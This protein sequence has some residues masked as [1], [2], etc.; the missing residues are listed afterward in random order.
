MGR[1]PTSSRQSRERVADSGPPVTSERADTVR[2]LLVT[3]REP[4]ASAQG[5]LDV[6]GTPEGSVGIGGQMWGV[7]SVPDMTFGEGTCAKLSFE[8]MHSSIVGGCNGSP[9]L[10]GT[11]GIDISSSLTTWKMCISMF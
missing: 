3:T 7:P 8:R 6:H 11:A 1:I 10:W 2:S 9:G 5:I 4:A